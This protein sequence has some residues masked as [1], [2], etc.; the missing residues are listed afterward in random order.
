MAKFVLFRF[1]TRSDSLFITVEKKGTKILFYGDLKCENLV[2][3]IL[4]EIFGS[5]RKIFRHYHPGTFHVVFN[6]KSPKT[7]YYKLYIEA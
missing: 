6:A 1:F 5:H 3:F 4:S 2:S 7:F